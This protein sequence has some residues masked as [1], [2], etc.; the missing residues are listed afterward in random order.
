MFK[1]NK[2]QACVVYLHGNSSSRLESYQILE[3]VLPLNMSLMAF[4]YPG[5]G[6]SEGDW[7]SLGY[8]EKEDSEK[9]IQFLKKNKKITKIFL[10]GRSMGASISVMLSENKSNMIAAIIADSPYANLKRLCLEL[11]SKK[12]SLVKYVFERAW[13]FMREKIL[14][15]YRFDIDELDIVPFS[16]KGNVPIMIFCSKE[17][18]IISFEHS[19]EIYTNYK[20][21]D[22]ELVFIKGSHNTVRDK[23]LIQEGVD[24]LYNVL[25]KT[26]KVFFGYD[27]GFA[28]H[29]KNSSSEMLKL[30]NM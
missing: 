13:K 15:A 7:V 2:T 17:D 11:G 12:T 26:G 29:I 4:D 23:I 25:G 19:K 21:P 22:K 9:I 20:C 24:F 16:Q 14:I 6:Q 30:N 18:E 5:C 28:Y 1:L 27:Y 10:W 8:Y 3:S